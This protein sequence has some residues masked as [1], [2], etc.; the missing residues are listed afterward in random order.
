MEAISFPH[1]NK[2]AKKGSLIFRGIRFQHTIRLSISTSCIQL[3]DTI[4]T[5]TVRLF[6]PFLFSIPFFRHHLTFFSQRKQNLT[7]QQCQQESCS[8]KMVL[9]SQHATRSDAFLHSLYMTEKAYQAAP[10]SSM[11]ESQNCDKG[12]IVFGIKND[13]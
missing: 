3:H 10:T 8:Y 11:G 13:I 6:S 1:F 12:L 4:T 7:R 5:G 9:S 2:K